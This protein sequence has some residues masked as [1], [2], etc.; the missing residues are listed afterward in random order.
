MK[1]KTTKKLPKA[2]AGIQ[3]IKGSRQIGRAH[4]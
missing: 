3:V 2:Q 1:K 4:V